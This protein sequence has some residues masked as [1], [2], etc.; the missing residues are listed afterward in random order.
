MTDGPFVYIAGPM[1]SV[2]GN[3]NFPLFDF[4]SEKLTAAGCQ[5]FSP[6]DHAR[7]I[8]GPLEDIQKL[9]KKTMAEMR[10]TLL[11]EEICWIIDKA[12]FV[13]MLPSW[14]RSSGAIAE[15]AVA[16]AV[17]KPVRE[18]PGH[19][20]MLDDKEIHDL[21]LVALDPARDMA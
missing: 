3:F 9:D 20:L 17:D 10:K 8:I 11:K 1:N 19:I 4:V 6:A 15:R 18:A 13:I 7:K 2:G 14:E 21:G 16:L 5:V 12:D